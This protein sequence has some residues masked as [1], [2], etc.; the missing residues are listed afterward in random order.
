MPHKK[1]KETV[2]D[3]LTMA[4]KYLDKSGKEIEGFVHDKGI[5]DS[6]YSSCGEYKGAAET[7]IILATMISQNESLRELMQQMKLQIDVLT[8]KVDVLQK[9]VKSSIKKHSEEHK[10]TDS[11]FGRSC[12]NTEN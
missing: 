8:E 9:Q 3:S 5:Y 10:R 1:T 7:K 4:Q 12:H 2:K 6:V 11:F